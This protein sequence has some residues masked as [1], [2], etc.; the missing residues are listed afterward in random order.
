MSWLVIWNIFL[1]FHW[2]CHV[3][4]TDFNSIIFRGWNHQ[5][6]EYE[7]KTEKNMVQADQAV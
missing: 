4:P 2:E 5:V 7:K 6:L 3:I 1:C